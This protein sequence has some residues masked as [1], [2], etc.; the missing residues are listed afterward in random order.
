[1]ALPERRKKERIQ[2]S[3]MQLGR[4]SLGAGRELPISLLNLRTS[5]RPHPPDAAHLT[6]DFLAFAL[7]KRW[8]LTIEPLLLPRTLFRSSRKIN[9]TSYLF[10]IDCGV[11]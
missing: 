2:D 10:P 3:V 5:L 4:G 1:M 11:R 6:H 9:K 8:S 7:A